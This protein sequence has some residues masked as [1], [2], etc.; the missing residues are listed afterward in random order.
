MQVKD[1]TIS[2]SSQYARMRQESVSERLKVRIGPDPRQ[3]ATLGQAAD[4]VSISDR[5]RAALAQAGSLS[6]APSQ[7]LQS[8]IMDETHIDPQI[9]M[10]KRIIEL[11]TGVEIDT[12][13]LSKILRRRQGQAPAELGAQASA[14]ATAP[15]P[16][17]SVE[18]DRSYEY[19]DFQYMSFDAEGL[20]TTVDGEQ[21]RFALSLSMQHE[22]S[23]HI[24]TS[25]RMHNGKKVDPIIINLTDEA[26]Q[27][28]DA[29]FEFDL[30][31]D[32]TT[33][34]IPGLRRG[35]GFLVLDRNGDGMVNDGTELFGPSTGN[36]MDELA[37][38]DSDGNGWL[39]E[40]DE[41]WTQLYVWT[42]GAAGD[43]RLVSLAQAGVGAI[44]LGSVGAQFQMKNSANRP[45]GELARMGL[46][47]RED[48]TVGAMQQIDFII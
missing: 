11:L 46:Y 1:S 41:V 15:E 30:D 35:S 13:E 38:H 23:V 22:E 3:S 8:V 19:H 20:I 4:R 45:L 24:T 18:Y 47:L 39:D 7:A 33:E 28:S 6:T 37:E 10:I 29:L 17:W 5:A 26:A 42:G 31:A 36:G 25:I 21:I 32:G 14:P 27:L 12:I 43:D 48:K 34:M 16:E 2:M 44:Y 40:R 9:R